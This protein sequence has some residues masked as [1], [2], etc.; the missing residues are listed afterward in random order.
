VLQGAQ[1][2]NKSAPKGAID[3]DAEAEM[4]AAQLKKLTQNWH[5]VGS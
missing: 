3:E 4:L 2:Q 1:K 5:T